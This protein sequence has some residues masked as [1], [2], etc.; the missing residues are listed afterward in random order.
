MGCVHMKV[1]PKT[2]GDTVMITSADSPRGFAIAAVVIE[3]ERFK[4]KA[5]VSDPFSEAAQRLADIGCMVL[6]GNIAKPDTLWLAMR[7]CIA[8]VCLCDPRDVIGK[9]TSAVLETLNTFAAKTKEM[10]VKI[11][12]LCAPADVIKSDLTEKISDM[13]FRMSRIFR[14]AP[15]CFEDF[16]QRFQYENESEGKERV[17]LRLNLDKSKPFRTACAAEEAKIIADSVQDQGM[18]KAGSIVALETTDMTM[19]EYVAIISN[20]SGKDIVYQQVDK[21]T[22]TKSKIL[23]HADT[24]AEVFSSY[25]ESVPELKGVNIVKAKISFKDWATENKTAFECRTVESP[26]ENEERTK[27]LEDNLM[28]QMLRASKG[29]NGKVWWTDSI[30]P[31]YSKQ[32]PLK[33]AITNHNQQ[34][35]TTPPLHSLEQ[36]P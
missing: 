22:M 29:C 21:A 12:A 17:V 30:A 34:P 33:Q 4:V 28:K 16:S 23:Q 25:S 15:F 19:G 3:M 26:R 31:Y 20:A 5:L 2:D 8:V 36:P 9:E 32:K 24:Y 27:M 13:G 14:C 18:Y 1:D 11:F 7:S 10:N 35:T 6:K